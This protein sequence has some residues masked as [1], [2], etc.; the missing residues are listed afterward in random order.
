MPLLT[1]LVALYVY[2]CYRDLAPTELR[3]PSAE[4]IPERTSTDV[5]PPIAPGHSRS[6]VSIRG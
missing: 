2:R 1:E 6:F 5:T 4:S 3:I